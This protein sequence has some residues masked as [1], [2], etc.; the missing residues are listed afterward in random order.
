MCHDS[1]G[2]DDVPETFVKSTSMIDTK[3]YRSNHG[4]FIM[5]FTINL[6]EL[7]SKLGGSVTT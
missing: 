7:I 3:Q 4:A 2:A 6:T 5:A 1:V